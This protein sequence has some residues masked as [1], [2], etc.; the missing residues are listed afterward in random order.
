LLATI[1]VAFLSFELRYDDSSEPVHFLQYDR[2]ILVIE[3]GFVGLTSLQDPMQL[4]CHVC[5]QLDP[6]DVLLLF[7]YS[8]PDAACRISPPVVDLYNLITRL[9]YLTDS[10]PS[11]A[12]GVLSRR[13]NYPLAGTVARLCEY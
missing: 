11:P 2:H 5:I 10:Q 1:S 4:L 3:G 8:V 12:L 13:P 9:Q 6:A 7:P